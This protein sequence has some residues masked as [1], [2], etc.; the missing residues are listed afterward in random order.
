MPPFS[1]LNS[2]NSPPSNV[3][4]NSSRS[5]S[6]QVRSIDRSIDLLQPLLSRPNCLTDNGC[7]KKLAHA[8]FSAGCAILA[9]VATVLRCTCVCHR[10]NPYPFPPSLPLSEYPSTHSSSSTVFLFCQ[11]T[12]ALPII[13]PVATACRP[14]NRRRR[15]AT[16]AIQH[17]HRLMM[18]LLAAAAAAADGDGSDG[19][20]RLTKTDR[21]KG[22]KRR[23]TCRQES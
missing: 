13:D 17:P 7:C 19:N 9:R 18:L 23:A 15:C 6:L 8:L 21:K 14:A 22:S 12:D 3:T 1:H 11:P 16:P 4:S 10:R 5:K 2:V 20:A